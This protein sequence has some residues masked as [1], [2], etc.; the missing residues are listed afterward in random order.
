[1]RNVRRRTVHGME[2]I[3]DQDIAGVVGAA[4]EGQGELSLIDTRDS[5]IPAARKTTTDTV[6]RTHRA[7]A[8]QSHSTRR[9]TS[10]FIPG[11]R[12]CAGFL[13]DTSD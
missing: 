7:P 12:L 9:R 11:L 4:L 8:R 2:S 3:H 10:R 5:R 13:L 6:G 1:M